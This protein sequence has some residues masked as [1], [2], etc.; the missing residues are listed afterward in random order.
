MTASRSKGTRR[1]GEDTD[2][3]GTLDGEHAAVWQSFG[4]MIRQLR[5][6]RGWTLREL[7][8]K[9]G[10]GQS[11]MCRIETGRREPS[12]HVLVPLSIHLQVR[13][14]DLLR[15]AEDEVFPTGPGMWT[16]IPEG[17][18]GRP[19]RKNGVSSARLIVISESIGTDKKIFAGDCPHRE[20]EVSVELWNGV[21]ADVAR[22][23]ECGEPRPTPGQTKD[24]SE[25][26]VMASEADKQQA[27]DAVMHA[28]TVENDTEKAKRLAGI[29]EWAD[30][31][32]P[33][34]K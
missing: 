21:L 22:C 15:I 25:E 10:V 3:P 31:K 9:C 2:R 8:N 13:L 5:Q 18:S 16:E 30:K 24:E 1:V 28:L 33:K 26:V 6:R 17:L 32:P 27:V 7:A 19:A 14:S 29:V 4:V 12:I 11:V 34:K 20:S 23:T